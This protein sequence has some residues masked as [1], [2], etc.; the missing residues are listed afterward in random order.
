MILP[1]SEP[2]TPMRRF[3]PHPYQLDAIQ[4]VLSNDGAGLLLDPGYGKTAI[5]L[6]TLLVL[7]VEP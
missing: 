3:E 6:A 5:T 2:A 1:S 7:G 4:F